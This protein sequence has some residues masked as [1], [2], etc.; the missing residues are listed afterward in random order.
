MKVNHEKDVVSVISQGNYMKEMTCQTVGGLF[1]TL[2]IAASI[3][4]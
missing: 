3:E 4:S 2:H 1:T